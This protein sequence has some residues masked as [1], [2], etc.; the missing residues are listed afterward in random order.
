MA[1]RVKLLLKGETT[2]EVV[3][4]INSGYEADTPQLMISISLVLLPGLWSPQ[5][6][7]ELTYDTAGGSLRVWLIPQAVK[8]QV[9]AE[10]A[11]SR[12]DATDIAISPLAE[13]PL[14]SDILAGELELAVED[15]AKGHWRFKWE[16]KEKTRTNEN[17]KQHNTTHNIKQHH[18]GKPNLNH[19]AKCKLK[20]SKTKSIIGI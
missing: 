10:D 5:N 2:K 12:E 6:A 20:Y 9:V 1:V 7:K 8:V 13:E 4:L 19:K 15:F 18:T 17:H 3:A 16:P 14:I 11:S